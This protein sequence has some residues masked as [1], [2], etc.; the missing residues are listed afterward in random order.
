M[1]SL[2][3]V[4][5]RTASLARTQ[6]IRGLSVSA[7]NSKDYT[8]NNPVEQHATDIE[9]YEMMQK[10][11]GNNDHFFLKATTRG[12]GTKEESNI[13]NAIDVYKMVGCVC[14]DE[15]TNIVNAIGTYKMVGCVCNDEDT[16]IE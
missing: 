3:R 9:K 11:K 7:V 2:T 10:Q 16:N 4:C 1:A 13:V 12:K 5:L 8:M 14:N 15:D 6:T